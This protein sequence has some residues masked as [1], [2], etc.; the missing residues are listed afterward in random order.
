MAVSDLIDSLRK[1]QG[2]GDASTYTE[3]NRIF[4]DSICNALAIHMFSLC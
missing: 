3:V 1:G 2:V 4:L